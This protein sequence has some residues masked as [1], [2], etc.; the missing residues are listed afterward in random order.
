MSNAFCVNE[1]EWND[2]K[3]AD[4]TEQPF[5]SDDKTLIVPTQYGELSLSI[6]QFGLRIQSDVNAADDFGMLTQ[7]P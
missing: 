3:A 4:I 6:S 2:I 7:A 5:L 1:P